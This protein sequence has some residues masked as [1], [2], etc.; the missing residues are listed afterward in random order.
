MKERLKHKYGLWTKLRQAFQVKRLRPLQQ[1]AFCFLGSSL[2]CAL[3][4]QGIP[5]PIAACS[6]AFSAGKMRIATLL[7]CIAGYCLF[8]PIYMAI[9]PIT[10]SLL[11]AI[12]AWRLQ[13]YTHPTFLWFH[14]AANTVAA[15]AVGF[16]M[17]W[18]MHF[19]ASALGRYFTGLLC[20]FF[21]SLVWEQALCKHCRTAWYIVA[22]AALAALAPFTLANF[23]HP[24][25]CIALFFSAVTAAVPEGLAVSTAAGIVLEFFSGFSFPFT[26]LLCLCSAVCRLVRRQTVFHRSLVLLL[27]CALF[28]WLLA[29]VNAQ[30]YLLSGIA[31]ALASLAF[32]KISFL[33]DSNASGT[34]QL[35]LQLQ[36]ASDILLRL[37]DTVLSPNVQASDASTAEIFD[38]AAD[39]VCKSCANWT[40]CWEQESADT[41]HALCSAARPMLAKHKAETG[42]FPETFCARCINLPCFLQTLNQQLDAMLY[43]RQF[44]S[45]L[46]ES[47]QML[48]NQYLLLARYLQAAV[49]SPFTQPSARYHPEIAACAVGK[50]GQALSGD[51]GACFHGPCGTF[52][53]LLCDGMGTGRAAKA[54]ST[55]AIEILTGLL[56]AGLDAV[57]ALALLN[58]AYVLRDNGCFATIDLL[59]IDLASG[60]SLL[61]KWGAAPSYLQRGS[62]LRRLGEASM[63]PGLSLTVMDK[64]QKIKLTLRSGDLLVLTSDGADSVETEQCIAENSNNPVQEIANR[65]IAAAAQGDDITAVALRLQEC[66]A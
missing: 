15:A 44:Q 35:R 7:G 26:A 59:Q 39:L 25:L 34:V 40:T 23:I 55:C 48:R 51:R 27:L 11:L 31:A 13:K 29:D 8:W 42:D 20:V 6:N 41:Y 30:I 65:I 36:Q 60:D 50:C 63:P 45:R 53:V 33:P 12:I 52:F 24:A 18:Q 22:V 38:H 57:S 62:H 9:W 2:L 46:N 1:Y 4:L 28:S 32:R 58:S 61:L 17:L 21:A 64:T 56:Q 47:R 5:T 14:P 49:A 54:E 37:H 10:L 66:A 3:P 16:G 19:P 43:R